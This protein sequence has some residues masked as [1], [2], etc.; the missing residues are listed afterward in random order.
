MTVQ[1]IIKFLLSKK[2]TKQSIADVCGVKWQTVNLWSK[3]AFKPKEQKTSTKLE[4]LYL[5]SKKK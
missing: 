2:F 5:Q 3:G 1:D 4:Q